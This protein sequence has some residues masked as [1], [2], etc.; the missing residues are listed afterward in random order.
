MI[1]MV[2]GAELSPCENYRWILARP[3]GGP[4]LDGPLMARAV[5]QLEAEYLRPLTILW[6]MLNPSTADALTNDQTIRKVIRYSK[7]AGAWRLLVCNLFGWRSTDPAGLLKAADPVGPRNDLWL[8]EALA[9]SST[10]VAAWGKGGKAA[11]LVQ[12]RAPVVLA[13]VRR[14]HVVH[15]LSF[16]DD[17]SPSHPLYLLG[18][19]KPQPWEVST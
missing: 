7:A 9:S 11:K 8:Q 3:C 17:G 5:S 15:A 1:T 19:L 16:N 10:V 18:D 4:L 12:A 2:E 6:L 13:Q 14:T